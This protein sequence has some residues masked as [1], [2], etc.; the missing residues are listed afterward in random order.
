MNE[1]IYLILYSQDPTLNRVSSLPTQIRVRSYL[2]VTRSSDRSVLDD[3]I[4]FK[5]RTIPDNNRRV[6]VETTAI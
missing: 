5:W 4:G 3:K 6:L 1:K 2:R